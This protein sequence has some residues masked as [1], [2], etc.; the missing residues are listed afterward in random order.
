MKEIPVEKE[1]KIYI[2]G[3]FPPR[4]INILEEKTGSE[5]K[6]IK[7]PQK[8]YHILTSFLTLFKNPSFKDSDIILLFPP[9][10]S[11]LRKTPL[12]EWKKGMDAILYLFKKAGKVILLSPFPSLPELQNFIPYV[13]ILEKIASLRNVEFVNLYSLY[14]HIE[15]WKRFFMI[16]NNIYSVFP[17]KE[18]VKILAEEILKKLK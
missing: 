11:I 15:N 2:V 16:N 8:G 6:V 13:N 12:E 7:F 18:G 3:D 5:F 10:L 4:L 9:F 1:S 17:D 14:T